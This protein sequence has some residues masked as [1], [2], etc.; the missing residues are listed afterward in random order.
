MPLIRLLLEI[1]VQRARRMVGGELENAVAE[2][3]VFRA[4]AGGGEEG[5]RRG[6]VRIFLE[7]MMLDDQA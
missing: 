2:P 5:F 1:A 3:D 7:E 6:R 4:L